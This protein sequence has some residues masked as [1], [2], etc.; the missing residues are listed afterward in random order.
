MKLTK[1]IDEWSFADWDF[2]GRNLEIREKGEWSEN[3][4]DGIGP[5]RYYPMMNYAYPLDSGCPSDSTI[6]E[7]HENTNLTVVEELS[8]GNF[9]LALT[10]GGMD[11]SQDIAMAYIIAENRVPLELARG[12]MVE[13]PL[14]QYGDNYLKVLRECRKTLKGSVEYKI[15]QIDKALKGSDLS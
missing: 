14:S 12:V 7:I 1:H 15:G 3:N 2:I 11:L 5:D 4:Q 9:Y 10:G 8:T 6:K 13:S